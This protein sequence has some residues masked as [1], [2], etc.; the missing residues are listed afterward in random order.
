[1]R[2][3]EEKELTYNKFLQNL[4]VKGNYLILNKSLIKLLG[5]DELGMLQELISEGNLWEQKELLDKEGFFFCTSDKIKDLFGWSWDK[6]KKILNKL[7]SLNLIELKLRGNPF[8]RY[9]KIN[10]NYLNTLLESDKED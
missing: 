6:Q 9:F 5:W 8:K 7:E 4:G 3:R 10:L 1:M 2:I